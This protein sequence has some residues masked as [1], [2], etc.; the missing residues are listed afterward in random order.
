[1]NVLPKINRRAWLALW[2]QECRRRRVRAPLAAVMAAP[3]LTADGATSELSWEWADADPYRW[4]IWQSIEGGEYFLAEEYWVT[5]AERSF[6]P[7]GGSESYI[8]VGVDEAGVEITGRSNAV[9]PDECIV[10]AAPFLYA[11]GA[12]S[13]LYWD[14][15]DADPYQW[16]IWQ[17]IDGGEYFLADEYLAVGSEHF[18]TPDGGSESYFVVGVDENGNEVTGRSNAV[19]PDDYYEE[20]PSPL[21]TDLLGYWTFDEGPNE[22]RADSSGN[23][24]DLSEFAV[25]EGDD[26]TVNAMSGIIGDCADFSLGYNAGLKTE[27]FPDFTGYVQPVSFSFWFN[28]QTDVGTQLLLT[29]GYE[30]IIAIQGDVLEVD[31]YTDGT[32]SACTVYTPEGSVVPDEWI[33]CA[34]VYTGDLL[35]VYL[36]GVASGSASSDGALLTVSEAF[37]ANVLSLGYDPAH[38]EVPGQAL[39]SDNSFFSDSKAVF[40]HG[41]TRP[42]GLGTC[43]S[44]PVFY[45]A[46]GRRLGYPLKLVKAKGHLFARW[47]EGR[48]RS[49]NIECTSIGFVSHTDE[50]YRTWPAPFKPDEEQ[51]ESYLKSLTPVQELAVFLTIRGECLRSSGDL[52]KAVGAMAQAFYKE[53]QSVGNQ[54]LFARAEYEAYKAGVL[55]KRA[56]LQFALRTLELPDGPMLN[57]FASQKAALEARNMAES[58]VDDIEMDLA[59][60]KAEMARYQKEPLQGA[61]QAIQTQPR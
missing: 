12:T 23:G 56:E 45:V 28:T 26:A 25:G 54:K 42:N 32:P 2:A 40:I 13:E 21:F 38:I 4:Q 35:T 36:N 15:E 47:D 18:F 27:S 17:S 16:Q 19:V 37:P 44:M 49:F 53:P 22:I 59:V 31:F 57:Y 43:S 48:S 30:I 1:M 5:G 33:H 9:V 10:M 39:E 58:S 46:I 8:V 55:P 61:A 3:V 14:W 51:S 50:E 7:D 34:V 11:D 29:V 20:P 24:L 41:M 6:T 52:L 60:L